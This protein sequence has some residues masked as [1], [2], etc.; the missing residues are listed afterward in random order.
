[1][2]LSAWVLVGILVAT[3]GLFISQTVRIEAT[4]LCAIAAL[5][6]TGILTPSEALSGFSSSATITVA[7]MLV[8]SAAL[9]KAGAI[10]M[11]V[12]RLL[13]LARGGPRRLLLAMCV[14]TAFFSAFMNNTPVV[15]L[16]IPVAISLSRRFHVPASKLLMPLSFFAILGGTCTLIGTSTNILVDSLYRDAGGPGF[17]MFEFTG[18]GA[19]YLGVGGLYILVFGPRILPERMALGELLSTTRPDKFVTEVRIPAGSRHVG[20]T[21]ESAFHGTER[22]TVIELVREEQPTLRP[23]PSTVLEAGDI[24]LLESSARRIHQLLA[25]P[26]V[27]HGTL[28]ADDQRVQIGHI[29]LHIAEALVTPGSSYRHREVKDLGL[30]RK[31]GVRILALRRLGRQHQYNLQSLAVLA[32]DVLLLEGSPEALRTLQQDGDVLLFEGIARSLT[33]PRK[34]P[35]AILVLLA[36]VG[37]AAFG[38]APIVLL[39]LLGAGVLLVCGCITVPDATRALDS[40]VLLLLAG[41]I[42]LGLAMQQTGLAAGIA[43]AVVGG[44]GP[45]GVFVLVSCLY[46]LTSVLT[47]T[48]SNNAAAVLLTPIAIGMAGDLGVDPKPLLVAIAFGASASFATPIGYQTN[49]MVMGPGGYRFGDYLRFGVPLNLL[50]WIAASLLIPLFW[51]A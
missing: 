27:E 43:G 16:M 42:P 12:H 46:L 18:M 34:A 17:G 5:A 11:L 28:V 39:S 8:I 29:D 21:L 24:L 1:M 32:G 7:A 50:L 35:V 41:T 10:D 49:T 45:Y 37:L 47:E 19:I 13:G 23:V 30:T 40:S 9:E 6:L 31:Y 44:A 48:L 51:P 4:A 26:D 3:V 38:V 14:P 20:K 2:A 25:A 15:A 22:V 33:V 36:V